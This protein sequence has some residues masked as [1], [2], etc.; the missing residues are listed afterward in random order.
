[1]SEFRGVIFTPPV[2]RID[3]MLSIQIAGP[4]QQELRFWLLFWDKIAWPLV[5]DMIPSPAE[6]PEIKFLENEGVLIKPHIRFLPPGTFGSSG[7]DVEGYFKIYKRL[8]EGTP[9]KWAIAQASKTFIDLLPGYTPEN[10]ISLELHKAIPVPDRDV[11]LEDILNFKDKRQSELLALRTTIES[12]L[13]TIA[14]AGDQEAEIARARNAI[15]QACADAIRVSKEWQFPIRLADVKSTM[16]INWLAI[17]TGG[18]IGQLLSG[19][20]KLGLA[21]AAAGLAAKSTLSTKADFSFQGFRPRQGPY[22]YVA[23]IQNEGI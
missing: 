1:M 4:T 22:R 7:R 11:P 21:G 9:G 12:Y 2:T 16:N 23:R 19:E 13:P 15:D 20:W 18:T 8:E 10:G 5:D 17:G 3:N 14:Q 6:E